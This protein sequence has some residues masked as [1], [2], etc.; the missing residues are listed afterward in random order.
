[1]VEDEYHCIIECGRVE[2]VRRIVFDKISQL[3]C[4]FYTMCSNDK[5]TYLM[6]AEG[7][8]SRVFGTLCSAIVG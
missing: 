4:K 7:E 5:C 2:N 1:M 3:N 6:T 8:I